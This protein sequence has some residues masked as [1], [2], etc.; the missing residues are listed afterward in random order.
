MR[1]SNYGICEIIKNISYVCKTKIFFK[2]ARMIRFPVVIR[3]RQYIDFGKNLTTGRNC[4]IEVNGIHSEK[5]QIF[6][7][8]VNIGDNVSIRCAD[9][10][11]IG[12]NVLMGSKVLI[13]DNSHGCYSGEKQDSPLVPPNKRKLSFAPIFIGDNVWIGENCVIQQGVSIG[14][15]SVI[16]AN[17]IVT[18]DVAKNTIVGGMP[19]HI[20]KNYNMETGKWERIKL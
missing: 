16:A 12:N 3:G 11:I 7:N 2:G 9:K 4:R 6:G 17:T 5:K 8:N 1:N 13:I 10:I 15:G 18:K 19:A 20:I 14:N